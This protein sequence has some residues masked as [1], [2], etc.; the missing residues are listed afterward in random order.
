[1][2]F[3]SRGGEYVSRTSFIEEKQED[4]ALNDLVGE[5]LKSIFCTYF[6]AAVKFGAEPGD[7]F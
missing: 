2:S 7:G 5:V 4:L 6:G 1:M 3:A